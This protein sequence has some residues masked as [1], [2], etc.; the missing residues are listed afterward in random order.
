M[1][2]RG[3]SGRGT[4]GLGAD[5]QSRSPGELGFADDEVV[6]ESRLSKLVP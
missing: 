3:F 4:T 6:M 5:L 1:A 2:G